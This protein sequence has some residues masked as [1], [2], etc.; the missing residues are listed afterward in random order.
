MIA[1]IFAERCTGCQACVAACPTHVFDTGADGVPLIARLDQCQ[2]CFMCE[3]YCPADALYVA[4]EQQGEPG[5]SAAEGWP[6]G[7]S[8]GY[9][10]I[11]AGIAMHRQRRRICRTSGNS[12]PCCAKGRRLP[13]AVMPGVSPGV[14][15]C[16][17]RPDRK[18]PST[19]LAH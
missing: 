13:R 9:A 3:L 8:A 18:S 17:E 2:T 15:T 10:M 19:A 16:R 6:W 12:A 1:Q 14:A 11:M 5:L 7:R 4:P